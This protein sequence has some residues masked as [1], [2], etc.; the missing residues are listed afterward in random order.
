MQL[1]GCRNGNEMPNATCAA[2]RFRL[3]I[4]FHS[5]LILWCNLIMENGLQC[6]D[7]SRNKI[8]LVVSRVRE[9]G[10]DLELGMV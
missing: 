5:F 4:A 1:T 6:N 9:G 2:S 10:K 8:R 3:K 7:S